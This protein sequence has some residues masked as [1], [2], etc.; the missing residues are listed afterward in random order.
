MDGSIGPPSSGALSRSSGRWQHWQRR[1]IQRDV[2]P[3][4]LRFPRRRRGGRTEEEGSTDQ[5]GLCGDDGVD[6]GCG[7]SGLVRFDVSSVLC[8][9][10]GR[11][12]AYKGDAADFECGWLESSESTVKEHS[13]QDGCRGRTRSALE[14]GVGIWLHSPRTT[15]V[16]QRR[17]NA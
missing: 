14:Q 6:I 8:S 12:I 3:D 11:R 10:G 15:S 1:R 13:T 2:E 4:S 5:V 16:A 17:S 7:R 9:K